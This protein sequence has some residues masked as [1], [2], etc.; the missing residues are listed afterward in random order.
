MYLYFLVVSLLFL[1]LADVVVETSAGWERERFSLWAGEDGRSVFGGGVGGGCLGC[2]GG[3][4]RSS[5]LII[6]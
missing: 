6:L 3:T 2:R 4:V 1:G 5:C